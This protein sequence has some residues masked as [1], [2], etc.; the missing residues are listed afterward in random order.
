[1]RWSLIWGD[2]RI[3]EKNEFKS[4]R[5]QNGSIKIAFYDHLTQMSPARLTSDPYLLSI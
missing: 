2:H 3:K 5:L 1:M 4:R